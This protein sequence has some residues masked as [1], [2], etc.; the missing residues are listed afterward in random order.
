[1]ED[2]VATASKDEL[3]PRGDF[4]QL[5]LVREPIGETLPPGLSTVEQIERIMQRKQIELVLLDGTR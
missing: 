4:D 3:D 1:M 5:V 2:N